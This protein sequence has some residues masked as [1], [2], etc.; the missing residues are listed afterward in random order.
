MANNIAIDGTIQETVRRKLCIGCGTCVALCP[1]KA[2]EMI[3]CLETGTYLPRLDDSKCN[4]CGLCLKICPGISNDIGEKTSVVFDQHANHLFVGKY[5]KCY[6]GYATNSNLRRKSTSGG[7]IPALAIF[8]LET[9]FATG[10]L[11]TRTEKESPLNPHSFIARTKEEVMSAMGSK[12]CPVPVNCA[13]DKVVENE[14]N[15]ITVGLPCHVQGLRKAQTLNRA[16][17][18]RISFVF[19]IVCNHTP[20]FH[21]IRFLLKKFKI[22]EEKIA[23]LDYRSKG[24][25]GGINIVM[26]DGSEHFISFRSSYYWG[27]VFQKFFWSKR[28]MVCDDKLCQL[29]DIIFMDAWLPVFSSEKMGYSLVVVRTRKGEEFITKAIEKGVVKLQQISIEAILESQSMQKT[30]RK[31]NA[32]RFILKYVSKK[33]LDFT[34]LS[35]SPSASDLLDAL[36]FVFTNKICK[37]NSKLTHLIIEYHVKLWN[38]ACFA[39]RKLVKLRTFFQ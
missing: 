17:E 3:E 12:Y 34:K 1:K 29:A 31:M 26:D 32:R 38:F 16:L 23:K 9:G 15:Y 6:S 8:A 35:Y 13:L 22:S 4:K 36:Y 30:I 20:T 24:W 18:T 2:L 39:K 37:N 21:A 33:P 14:G 28:C 5:L 27:Y 11:T 7:L 19:G 25:P 10:I